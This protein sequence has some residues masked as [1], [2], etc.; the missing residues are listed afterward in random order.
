LGAIIFKYIK[1]RCALAHGFFDVLYFLYKAVD[2]AAILR[3]DVV[4]KALSL[5]TADTREGFEVVVQSLKIL[6]HDAGNYS[7]VVA[8]TFLT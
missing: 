6:I 4:D 5:A 3:E 2:P 1:A 7:I 8:D